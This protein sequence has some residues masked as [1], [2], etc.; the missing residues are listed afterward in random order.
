[1]PDTRDTSAE[2]VKH[3]RRKCGTSATRVKNFDFDNDTSEIIFSHPYS[4]IEN[5]RLQGEKQF[6]S[7]SYILEI[8]RFHGKMRLKS[9]PQKLNFVIAKVYQNFIC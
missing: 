8:S 1:M 7:K 4:Y 2:R 9:A 5:K 6:Y 3:E